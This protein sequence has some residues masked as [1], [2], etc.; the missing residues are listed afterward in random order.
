[1]VDDEEKDI[2]YTQ[3]KLNK[4]FNIGKFVYDKS[5]DEFKI[6]S[7]YPFLLTRT[8]NLVE[9]MEQSFWKTLS[10]WYDKTLNSDNTTL[11]IISDKKFK[12]KI[13]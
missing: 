6:K 10:K 1:M 8:N 2:I 12:V 13:K 5:K 11:D 3:P 9:R 4:D 7:K